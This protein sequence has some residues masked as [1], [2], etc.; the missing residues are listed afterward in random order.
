MVLLCSCKVR[1]TVAVLRLQRQPSR[2]EARSMF[3]YQCNCNAR[4]NRAHEMGTRGCAYYVPSATQAYADML[5]RMDAR[6][7]DDT[8]KSA[9][10]IRE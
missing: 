4:R 10:D 7:Y 3:E 5:K 1:G 2:Y 6:R 9:R 8:P